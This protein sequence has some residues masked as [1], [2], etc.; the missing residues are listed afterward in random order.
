M[1]QT[2]I[3]RAKPEDAASVSQLAWR[4]KSGWGYPAEWLDLWR[5]SL[6][7]TSEYL[8]A[9]ESLVGV[10]GGHVVGVCILESHGGKG[11]LQHVWIGPE[12]QGQGIG[13][14]L[15]ERALNMAAR[16]GVATVEVES[17]PF[18]EAFYTR[19][20]ARRMG[21]VS[22]PMPGAPERTL[23]LLKFVLGT[24]T[25]VERAGTGC[26]VKKGVA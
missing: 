7:M 15:V 10:Q 26:R 24:G 18:A 11:F 5:Q 3:R 17:D 20:G 21:E 12:H 13:R 2:Q 4:A 22:A 1:V 25:R 16:A 19:L 14:A 8:R 9:H 6:T 23:P